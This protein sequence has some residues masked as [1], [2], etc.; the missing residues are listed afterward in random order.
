LARGRGYWRRRAP[1]SSAGRG[2]AHGR[3]REAHLRACHMT[4]YAMPPSSPTVSPVSLGELSRRI[5]AVGITGDAATL[6]SGLRQDSR[7]IAPGDVFALRPGEKT[8]G[9]L[10]VADAVRRGAVALLAPAGAFADGAP[11]PTIFVDDVRLA[12]GRAASIVYGDP[13]RALTVV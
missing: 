3:H 2:S 11:L 9:A 8:S 12:I 10:F 1:R 6:A 7:Q 5:G 13:T 4:A